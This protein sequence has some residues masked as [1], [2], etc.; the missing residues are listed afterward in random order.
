M[1]SAKPAA[2]ATRTDVLILGAGFSGLAAA[3]MLSRAG[4]L[5]YVILEQ[6]NDV[7]GTWRENTYP[8]CACDIPSPLYSYSFRQN[9]DWR[10]LFAGQPEIL[11]YLRDT[12]REL[13][14]TEHIRFNTT[15]ISADWDENDRLWAVRTADGAMWQARFLVSAMGVL[16]HAANPKLPGIENFQGSVFHSAN[17]DHSCDLTD[18]RVA[19]VGTGAS[20]IQ[21]VPAIVDRTAQLSVF[22]RTAPW[23]V[24]KFNRAFTEDERK[25]MRRNPFKRWRRR[26]RLFW[27]HEQRA[28]GFVSDTSQMGPTKALATAHLAKQV[29][30]PELR[31]KLTPDY[32][33]GCKRLLISSEYYPA[34][35][36][37]HVD[38]VT[39]GIAEVR[40]NSVIATD[41]SEYDADVI[42]FGTGF[43]AQNSLT[44]VPIRGRDGVP[45]GAQWASGPE[46]YLGTTVSGFPNLF[47]L[48]GPNTG[49]G[50]NSQVFMIEA[51]ARYMA[52][53]IRYAGRRGVLE[54]KQGAQV[55][56]NE[57]LQGR[58]SSTV[59][60]AGGCR[61][62]Y[63]DPTTGR[64][65]LLWPRSTVSYWLRTRFVQRTDYLRNA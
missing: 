18:K 64:N 53:C 41:G 56:F 65:T 52:R 37:P 39:A 54:V 9:P 40:A 20:A 46:A 23:I 19:V 60:Q 59:W 50:H 43:D 6:G 61:S 3:A 4:R 13:G 24:P 45:L 33:I 48:C 21:F 51:Q 49:L 36:K 28:A 47:L 58:L 30:D 27:I 42:I 29:R 38:L 25:Q 32:E 17:W 7:G 26:A 10:Y 63:Q 62:W 11:R 55:R 5:D 16:H 14:I 31:A 35:T 12:G 34:L 8:G 44:R 57:F 1:T 2:D 22:Q 15:V